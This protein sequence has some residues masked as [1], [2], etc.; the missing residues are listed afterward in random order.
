MPNTITDIYIPR[1]IDIDKNNDNTSSFNKSTK[2]QTSVLSDDAKHRLSG[3]SKTIG[4][5]LFYQGKSKQIKQRFVAPTRVNDYFS[6]YLYEIQQFCGVNTPKYRYARNIK[7]HVNKSDIKEF[8]FSDVATLIPK[9]KIPLSYVQMPDEE[10]F[11]L[12]RL[13]LCKDQK[14]VKINKPSSLGQ[15]ISGNAFAADL[16]GFLFQNHDFGGHNAFFLERKG[17]Q[18]F[19]AIDMGESKFI[20][21]SKVMGSK[22]QSH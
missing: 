6:Y 12:F 1:K 13:K 10:S 9:E 20:S 7:A 17:R 11:D 2:Y 5:P 14:L 16:F 22:G 19:I 3:G 21:P 4:G 18:H 8:P 15:K